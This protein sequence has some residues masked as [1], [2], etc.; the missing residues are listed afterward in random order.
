[1]KKRVLCILL[2]L[3][4]MLSF[5][6]SVYAAA[7]V[8][9]GSCGDSATYTL[10]STGLLTISGTGAVKK[11]FWNVSFRSSIKR[12]V[13]QEGITE[14]PEKCFWDCTALTSVQL[15]STLTGIANYAF[16]SC[17]GLKQIVI[18][19]GVVSVGAYAFSGCTGLTQITLPST[20]E[21]IEDYA[22]TTCNSVTQIRIPA[23]LRYVGGGGF[24][25]WNSL[26]QVHISDMDAW[27]AIEFEDYWA[28]PMTSA[29]GMY[30]NG[31]PVREVVI[32][33]GITKIQ[34]AAF[35]NIKTLEQVTIPQSVT[36]MGHRAFYGCSALKEIELPEGL[37]SIPGFGFFDC[38]LLEQVTIPDSVTAIGGSAFSGCDALRILQWPASVQSVGGS[39]FF[40]CFALDEV[41]ITD[42]DAWARISFGDFYA[43]PMWWGGVLLVHGEPLTEYAFPE[44]TTKIGRN[45]FANC[46]TLTQVRIPEGVTEIGENAFMN[47]KN[48]VHARLPEGLQTIG[49]SAFDDCYALELEGIPD[50]V[51]SI[52]EYAFSNCSS[53]QRIVIP[54]GV[55]EIP[56]GAFG[57]NP[58]LTEVEFHDNITSIG[59]MAFY[60]TGLEKLVLPAKLQSIGI[61][62]FTHTN[63]KSIWMPVTVTQIAKGAFQ[64]EQPE[65]VYYYGSKEQWNAISI[66]ADNTGLTNATIFYN[67]DQWQDLVDMGFTLEQ[68]LTQP[69]LV[70]KPT[71]DQELIH[72]L[73]NVTFI[74][75]LGQVTVSGRYTLPLEAAIKEDIVIRAP[76]YRDYILP[77]SVAATMW[78]G[79]DGKYE[80][81]TLNAVMQ[82]DR[83]DGKPYISTVFIRETGSGLPYKDAR[84]T[85]YYAAKGVQYDLV[86]TSVGMEG[87]DVTYY[88]GQN[89]QN[90]IEST[91][92]RFTAQELT[93]VFEYGK[94]LYVYASA[95]DG[96]VCE[97]VELKLAMIMADDYAYAFLNSST[98]S[99]FGDNGLK[100]KVG[101]S[102]PVLGGLEVG[103][104]CFSAPIGVDITGN[105]V[106]VSIGFDIFSVSKE[107]DQKAEK[108][109]LFKSFKKEFK[110]IAGNLE[111]HEK[112]LQ[113]FKA[114]K[115]K[116]DGK[117]FETG[118][119]VFDVAFMG[120][121]EGEIVNGELIFTEGLVSLTGK[122][123]AAHTKYALLGGWFPVYIAAG[124]D[125]A[126]TATGT[127]GRVVADP[128]VP[129][130]FGITLDVVP[131]LWLEGGAGIR[132]VMSIGVYGKGGAPYHVNFSDKY[133]KWKLTGELGIRGR[134]LLWSMNHILLDGEFVLLEEYYGSTASDLGP[135]VLGDAESVTVEMA[136]REYLDYDSGWLGQE[137]PTTLFADTLSVVDFRI[138]QTGIYEEAKPQLTK[139]GDK[140][141]LTWIQDDPARDDFN[142]M[143][144]VYSVYDAASD[145]WS[146]PKPVYDDGCIDANATTA[147][148][149][150]KLV[151]AWQ[152]LAR[153]M[154]AEDFAGIDALL[155]NVEIYVAVYDP[156]TDTVQ[157]VQRVTENTVFDY[158]PVAAALNGQ[159]AV[160]YA[161]CE[162]ND[163]LGSANSVNMWT[164]GQGRNVLS[165]GQGLVHT[166]DAE[167]S[168]AAWIGQ[169]GLFCF[170]GTLT[171]PEETSFVGHPVGLV[172]DEILYITDGSNIYTLSGG[173]AEPVLGSNR[174]IGGNL[175]ALSLGDSTQL[176]WMETQ[177]TG[178][179]LYRVSRVGEIWTEPVRI[180]APNVHISCVD[181]A[182][183]A[184]QVMGA[185]QLTDSDGVT[186]LA[187]FAIHDVTDI[188]VDD[189]FYFDESQAEPGSNMSFDVMLS[190]LGTTDITSVT[191]TVT[192]TLGTEHCYTQSL[193][194]SSGS[195]Q[196]LT[197]TYPVP[198][199]F[200]AT[201]LTVTAFVD[202]DGDTSNNAVSMA[203]GQC[204]LSVNLR[205]VESA[206]GQYLI[207][208][209]V[210]NDSALTAENVRLSVL[211]D[212][213]PART[214][215]IGTLPGGSQAAV[216]VSLDELA[217]SFGGDGAAK[218]QMKVTCDTPLSYTDDDI[219]T[220]TLLRQHTDCDH[221]Q[222]T[223]TSVTPPDCLARG[224]S[225][226]RCVTCGKTVIRDYVDALGHDHVFTVTVTPTEQSTGVLSAG[227]S[228]CEDT[229][230]V[231]L[232]ML[233]EENYSYAVITEPSYTEDGLGRY[234]WHE[235]AYGE[236]CIDVVLPDL[237]AD[238][239][240]LE[241]VSYPNKVFY[242]LGQELDATGLAVLVCRED[243]EKTVLTEGFDLTALDSSTAGIK[244]ITVTVEE[245]SVQLTVAVMQTNDLYGKCGNMAYWL[246]Q[247]GE[248]SL[249]VFG[250]GATDAMSNYEDKP[251][252]T[253]R[254]SITAIIVEDGITKIGDYTFGNVTQAKTL[255]LGNTLE[256]I[257][258]GAFQYCRSLT[259][260]TLPDS[261]QTLSE[262]AFVSCTGLTEVHVSGLSQWFD[263]EF[264][265]S[266]ANPLAQGAR[267][268]AAGETFAELVVPSGVERI[269][270]YQF[271][272]VSWLT[273]VTLGNTVTRIGDYA[274][275]G[276]GALAE[277]ILNGSLTTIGDYAFY[278]C[279]ALEKLVLGEK[280]RTLGAAAFGYTALTELTLPNSVL[281]VGRSAFVQCKALKTVDFGDGLEAIGGFAFQECDGLEEVVLPDSLTEIGEYAF[282][283]CDNLRSVCFGSGLKHI[284]QYAFYYSEAAFDVLPMGLES[285]ETYAFYGCP[286]A[287]ELRIGANVAKI[288]A[289]A[290]ASNRNLKQLTFLGGQTTVGEYAFQY[291]RNLETVDM[292]QC[293]GQFEKDAFKECTGLTGVYVDSLSDWCAM[294]FASQNASPLALAGTLFVAGE[295]LRQ[296]V[297]PLDISGLPTYAF[298]GCTSLREV[299][300]AQGMTAVSMYA[301]ADC[302]GLT[303]V[304]VPE[305]IRV[306]G[307]YAFE[308]C[309]ELVC[310]VLPASL[311]NIYSGAFQNCV[312]LDHVLYKGTDAQR[313]KISIDSAY[314]TYIRNATWHCGAAGH[315]VTKRDSCSAC[316][317]HCSICKDH[318]LTV[319]KNPAQHEFENGVCSLCNAIENLQYSISKEGIVTVTGYTGSAS[320]LILPETIEGYPLRYIETGAFAG[321]TTL[322]EVSIADSV[323]RMGE[324]ILAGCSALRKLTVP[325]LG[326]NA[327]N[328]YYYPL[329]YLFGKEFYDG[330]RATS[331]RD[332][333]YYIPKT[334]REVVF[335]GKKI[336]Y[337]TFENCVNLESIVL[338]DKL[339]AIE[340][341]AF[342][343]CKGL[344]QLEIPDSVA[345][346][347]DGAFA[348]CTA[349]K[350][351]TIPDGIQRLNN[352][353]FSGCTALEQVTIPESVT[354][355]GGRV[356]QKCS[357]LK[358]VKLPAGLTNLGSS[359]F[360]EC[361]SLESIVIPQGVTKI[362]MGSFYGCVSLESVNIPSG[363]TAIEEQA[364]SACRALKEITIPQ[365]VTEIGNYAFSS[366]AGL[367]EI[368]IPQSVKTIGV[369]AFRT[370]VAAERIVISDGVTRIGNAAFRD[371]SSLQEITV[372]GSVTSLGS[373]VF[374]GCSALIAARLEE[375][376]SSVSEYA[377]E[378]CENLI[379]V[380]LPKS[381]T[382]VKNYAFYNC[383]ALSHV[384]YQGTVEQK[385]G[386]SIADVSSDLYDALWHYETAGDEI[387][388]TRYCAGALAWCSI[389]QQYVGAYNA[390]QAEHTYENGSCTVCGAPEYW[391]YIFLPDGT[392]TV[393]LY[394]GPDTTLTVP[395]TLEGRPA[396]A[397][398]NSVFL[399]NT[400]ITSVT[401][402]EGILTLGNRVFES[403]VALTTVVLPEGLTSIGDRAFLQ[404]RSLTDMRIPQSVTTIGYSA[405][406]NCVNLRS[407]TLP[408]QLSQLGSYAFYSCKLLEQ[409]R[410][411]ETVSEIPPYCFADCESLREVWIG[412]G[413]TRIGNG[414]FQYCEA[415]KEIT[416]RADAPSF[417]TVAFDNLTATVYYPCGNSTWTESV[418]QDYG[419]NITW[420]A[421]H[422]YIEHITP[423]GHLTDGFTTH[424]C[425]ICG[426][427]YTDNVVPAPGHTVV[428]DP[429]VAPSCTEAGWTEGEHCEVCQE[430][431]V[432][433]EVI[434]ALDH[435]WDSGVVTL[436]PTEQTTGLREHT[437]QRCGE[438]ET[439]EIPTLDHVHRYEAQIVA[440]GCTIGGYT[441][442]TCRCADSY[443]DD[444]VDAV[445]HSWDEGTVIK[446]PTEQTTGIRL[447]SC[448]TCGE[449]REEVLPTIEHVHFYSSV[450]HWP[451]C[452]TI[453]FTSH[454]CACGHTYNDQYKEPLGHLEI[455]LKAVEPSCTEPGLTE[456]SFCDRCMEILIEQE[457]HPALGHSWDEGAVIEEPTE[458]A[459]GLRRYSCHACGEIR[460]EEIPRLEH[461]H[462][463]QAVRTE[464]TCAKQGFITQICPCGHSYV[465]ELLP[466]PPHELVEQG[467]KEPTCTEG[468]YTGDLVCGVCGEM[469][470]MGSE[471]AA[472]GHEY[473][474]IDTAPTCTEEGFSTYTCHCGE[475]YTDAYVPAL[476]HSL[477][478]WILT[479]SG[480][481]YRTCYGCGQDEIMEA[482]PTV[483]DPAQAIVLA[484][485]V[486]E[487]HTYEITMTDPVWGNVVCLVDADGG[488]TVLSETQITETG[489]RI[490]LPGS[491][492]IIVVN[493]ALTFPDVGA[494]NRFRKDADY[495]TAR[496]IMSGK[497]DGT[498]GLSEH[499]Q[500]RTVA[501]VLWRLAGE[502][503]V[504]GKSPFPD[505]TGGRYL[506]P[507]LWA[508]QNGIIT[509]YT[510][511][512]FRPTDTISRQH[513]AVML[514]RYAK[515]A[516]AELER[517]DNGKLE[518]FPDYAAMNRRFYEDMQWALDCGLISGKAN[519][520]YDPTGF[521]TRGQMTTVLSR[522]LQK[523]Y[524]SQN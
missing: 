246:Y 18:P 235:T 134:F 303:M 152:K 433:R 254:T 240:S 404:C 435:S 94:K 112:A 351:I 129:V 70:I 139:V 117:P 204:D 326:G 485:D 321:C 313:S 67:C 394:T 445:G 146:A 471:I 302:T 76:G 171:R 462:R 469:Q 33:E 113:R 314:S 513:F 37:T 219:L 128:K 11:S 107:D 8:E 508:Y 274:F 428:V 474:C 344:T 39:A 224:Y 328:G 71:C 111:D 12:V 59:E 483:T 398:G 368:V 64:Y 380:A 310:V 238:V 173:K 145:T 41:R 27:C 31:E 300:F 362:S 90:R 502:P 135:L 465:S 36:E 74:S 83:K 438:K 515:W 336:P 271:Y 136:D 55:T 200:T 7:V 329:G 172:Y 292:G 234:T 426:D 424:I 248:T 78:Q 72:S 395:A 429:A 283:Y 225:S 198:V 440:P 195:T 123:S 182:F 91:T 232:P 324:G 15:P 45:I 249:T 482:L 124:F 243:G 335:T 491:S 499:I 54:Q 115:N 430:T 459:E 265:D 218:V 77:V 479:G 14:L 99:L 323:T 82:L 480:Q 411:P 155:E 349:L 350:Q 316:F 110:G 168:K 339:T 263:L 401:V 100:L 299:T 473:W 417:E 493:R 38:V 466:M 516:N 509:G 340:S 133:H 333:T 477:S 13:V 223:L 309:S 308:G 228:R 88:I 226:Y 131:E 386:I 56:K 177:E 241:I 343:G 475:S 6:P 518:D 293:R 163:L 257:G 427:S 103:M 20:L 181:V 96:T 25:N 521:T 63:V 170:D 284:R 157:S 366:C 497:L 185:C 143:R 496:G 230:T 237:V 247:S 272:G 150:G 437:C 418:R 40:D 252:E 19:E 492:R 191:L 137:A 50:S 49:R 22:F 356:F 51:S 178:N 416:F 423:P 360:R 65:Y 261:L 441:V 48:L 373:R 384:L 101:D 202:G 421:E 370:C 89:E 399:G 16:S 267:L 194:L 10:D 97:P 165:E 188:A 73:E 206:G 478:G 331:Q 322:E 318:F 422:M 413:V 175:T 207:T 60:S 382:A 434:P 455:P 130:D 387:T 345:T 436:K 522:F 510:D 236:I 214:L 450:I 346:L 17:T 258:T 24:A 160:Y 294:S 68:I 320:A 481:I 504:E 307:S 519:G 415:L 47:C 371:C 79:S 286:G 442:Y 376:I 30:L 342:L 357:A 167:G 108:D 253:V 446:A 148:V 183:C 457:E 126:V 282:S 118:K 121:L 500:R 196:M 208:A 132:N 383:D 453:G 190:N 487:K 367:K 147:V 205:N 341:Y 62:A 227:C 26:V 512:T 142:R 524:A 288:G 484:V 338:T 476:G 505:V 439:R 507:V 255:S 43:N 80:P 187:S 58:A 86:V 242:S 402:P 29:Q 221:P 355:L 179:A 192:D 332:K 122:F 488:Y 276:C 66:G 486:L 140:L 495:L 273:S 425:S 28:N 277:G 69:S 104:D 93:T 162:D 210:R 105:R 138:L 3:S 306:I 21:R 374:Q 443:Y 327:D 405:F 377:F 180:S 161:S 34:P 120:Y 125:G 166:L 460:E 32:P 127:G 315:E 81:Y 158:L 289:Y 189:W 4:M 498:Y 337:R 42:P 184:D 156:A 419:G 239:I 85:E 363:V 215:S 410:I 270:N 388:V 456:G 467:Y 409:I 52:G 84:V 222:L 154:T 203:V 251:W 364:F 449:T 285:I 61:N 352:D 296:L 392:V 311:T 46:Q 116:Y 348:D 514:H 472:R 169:D 464:S 379:F 375:G 35:S 378:G 44:G 245:Y 199:H 262:K 501:M 520:T 5:V 87:K 347:S 98:F 216:E 412:D 317:W 353:L 264:A 517:T 463:Y 304:T 259:E 186:A 330:S 452:T 511:G 334:L 454:S 397:I 275:Y 174:Q 151:I 359:A 444:Y 102:F 400:A 266:N 393:T 420:T 406:W 414:A 231:E 279:A 176:Y 209:E 193:L 494:A 164:A 461:I 244:K 280:V 92:G 287:Q 369:E 220:V 490:T 211:V 95:S 281:T 385:L 250:I 390:P 381:V 354:A 523:F 233:N 153:T 451:G 305:G 448:D 297:I 295:P 53:I 141:V 278:K 468:G 489:V 312:A 503:Q 506:M 365:G 201:T 407:V 361:S 260:L 23:S 212:G 114:L 9:S 213:Q 159:P 325:F 290:F 109:H 319:Q 75:A 269:G 301:F 57:W 197:V 470:E 403:C 229:F 1:M 447:Y 458:E 268:Y 217:L 389:C 408:E 2:V 106:R 298:A 431:L 358:T 149:D 432:A 391:Q 256:S 372:P 119:R 144:L 291:C 396:T